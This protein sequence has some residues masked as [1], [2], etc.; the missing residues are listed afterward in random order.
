MS[1]ILVIEDD[2]ELNQA[3][4]YTL[5]RQG[6]KAIPAFSMSEAK[7]KYEQSKENPGIHCIIQDVNLP[8]GEGFAFYPLAK[9]KDRK[10]RRVG[11]E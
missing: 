8:D 4:C 7:A 2:R 6:Y 11:K 10:S 5:E 1:G 9:C 3:L